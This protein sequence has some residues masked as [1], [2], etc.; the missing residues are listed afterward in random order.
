MF[1]RDYSFTG[2][3]LYLSPFSWFLSIFR[4]AHYAFFQIQFASIFL[5]LMVINRKT[6]KGNIIL[7]GINSVFSGN[8]LSWLSPHKLGLIEKNCWRSLTAGVFRC[9]ATYATCPK[10][11]LLVYTLICKQCQEIKKALHCSNLRC[12]AWLNIPCHYLEFTIISDTKW[13]SSPHT[14]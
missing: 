5:S 10:M 8:P 9:W 12:H 1:H 11:L 2:H 4:S 14:N 13:I 7:G 3:H 6:S